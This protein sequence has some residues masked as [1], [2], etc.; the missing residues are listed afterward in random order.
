V[1]T[2]STP[3]PISLTIDLVVG[4]VR[5]TASDRA[6]TVVDVR[7]SNG[8]REPDIQ[9][10]EQARVEFSAGRLLIKAPK[11]RG[12]GL[13]GRTGSVD[14]TVELPTG[15]QL[16]GDAS[17]G[18]FRAVGRLGD[19][20]ISTSTGEVRLGSVGALHLNTGAGAVEVERVAGDADV[21]TGMGRIS[22]PRIDGSAVVK[23]SDGD[24]WVGQISGDLWLKTAD[25]GIRVDRT[26]G[27]IRVATANGNIRI[28]EIVR[29]M[30]SLKTAYGEIEFGIA[31]GT[32]ARL[33]VHTSYGRVHNRLKV[34]DRPEPSDETVEVDAHT[35]YGDIVIRRAPASK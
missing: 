8:F 1:P 34:A 21:R 17:E 33:D 3:N 31:R 10:A 27:D 2:F 15:S 26:G 29:G 18:A 25:G 32:A 20:R 35:S 5:I 9:A 28:G 12:L 7:P 4:D 30:A 19:C 16:D 23:N 6:D 13:F 14:V 22:L 11:Q 24:C